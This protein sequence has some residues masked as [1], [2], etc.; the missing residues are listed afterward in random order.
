MFLQI[1]HLTI[2]NRAHRAAISS[3]VAH[4]AAVHGIDGSG[5]GGDEDDGRGGDRVDLFVGRM[6]IGMCKGGL[7]GKGRMGEEERR[8]C[9]I[10]KTKQQY[11]HND[12]SATHPSSPPYP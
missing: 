1:A 12:P 6:R 7:M 11:L 4:Q 8:D 2:H 5:G 10:E 9:Q 3:P